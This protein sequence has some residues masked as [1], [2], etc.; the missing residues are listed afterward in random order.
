MRN[1][2]DHAAETGYSGLFI[3][4]FRPGSFM[5]FACIPLMVLMLGAVAAAQSPDGQFRNAS[6]PEPPCVGEPWIERAPLG[7]ARSH[8]DFMLGTISGARLQYR[9]GDH[10]DSR[11]MAEGVAGLFL[12]F[13]TAGAGVR[14]RG[15]LH[16]GKTNTLSI[17]P[18]ADLY[19][20]YIFGSEILGSPRNGTG[21]AALGID[22]DFLWRHRYGDTCEGVLGF[23]LG[24]AAAGTNGGGA[25][26]PIVSL[27]GGLRF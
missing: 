2:I 19:A 27:V 23:K 7:E 6:W 13:P 5:R 18:G 25:L 15:I 14:Y 3:R 21:G 4:P 12:I 20:F 10:P 8:L 1:R 11:W 26:V 9:L 16:E 24:A 17:E 22:A